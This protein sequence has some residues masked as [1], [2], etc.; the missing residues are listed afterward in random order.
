MIG[1]SYTEGEAVHVKYQIH[2]NLK[3]DGYNVIN[4]GRAGSGP[5]IEYGIFK[6]YAMQL[7]PEV[8][9]WFFHESSDYRDL[10]HEI[11][12]PL[13]KDYI[14]NDM[15][16]QELLKKQHIIDQLLLK[17]NQD[18]EKQYTKQKEVNI[19]YQHNILSFVGLN[20]I[21]NEI[22][23]IIYLKPESI[24]NVDAITL[25]YI[26]TILNKVN[27][28]TTA[29]GGKLVLIYIPDMNKLQ[30]SYTS[31]HPYKNKL[32][33]ILKKIN[34]DIIDLEHHFFIDKNNKNVVSKHGAHFN[35]QGYVKIAEIIKV[36][37][38]NLDK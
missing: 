32:F 28:Y 9:L 5:L 22:Q 1:D 17:Y 3:N 16:S 23:K 15:F 4:F 21:W 26:E 18:Q 12:A 37:L 25:N 10:I 29:W 27:N 7:K 8:V 33:K 19:Y 20:Y 2:T 31:E 11:K 24:N 35:E 38:S 30:L 6:E 13:L 34:I 14:Y 36:Y